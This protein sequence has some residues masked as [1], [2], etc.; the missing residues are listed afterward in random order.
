MT[1]ILDWRAYNMN[2]KVLG[3]IDLST[4]A[5]EHHCAYEL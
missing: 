1:M 3:L 4:P 5:L 2:L